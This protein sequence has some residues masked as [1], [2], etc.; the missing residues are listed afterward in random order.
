MI[1]LLGRDVRQI[2]GYL[3]I[4]VAHVPLREDDRRWMIVEF[5]IE[6]AG[7][8]LEATRLLLLIGRA[9]LINGHIGCQVILR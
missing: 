7:R 2:L 9:L 4:E 3:Y 5:G 1:P 6:R 8:R